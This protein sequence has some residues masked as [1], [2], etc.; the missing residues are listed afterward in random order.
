MLGLLRAINELAPP[1]VSSS[2]PLAAFI[3]GGN[4]KA[5]NRWRD[6]TSAAADHAGLNGNRRQFNM[7]RGFWRGIGRQLRDAG[8]VAEHCPVD[9][10]VAASRIGRN[11]LCPI[12]LC[13]PVLTPNG[14][15]ALQSRLSKCV[16]ALRFEADMALLPSAG[17]SAGGSGVLVG[18]NPQRELAPARKR[19]RKGWA[20]PEYRRKRARERKPSG[21]RRCFNCGEPG[22]RKRVCPKILLS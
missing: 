22:H 15:V 11:K 4:P 12:V 8:L 7:R 10:L 9:Q 16:P 19:Q 18:L 20:D 3:N 1:L 21:E 14:L 2:S 17:G 6:L 13:Q 5:Q